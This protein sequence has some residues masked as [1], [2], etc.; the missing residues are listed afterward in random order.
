M[1]GPLDP[2][3]LADLLAMAGDD[4]EVVAGAV[5]AWLEDAPRQLETMRRAAASGDDA[6]LVRAATALRARSLGVGAVRVG[7]LA[8][9]VEE[10]ARRGS[11]EEAASRLPVLEVACEE[12][13]EALAE[14][15]ELGWMP[16]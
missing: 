14:A 3:A 5:D 1:T 9:E 10:L 16:E 4:P 2:E 15:S 6:L 12:T 13:V 7:D 8:W 11:A